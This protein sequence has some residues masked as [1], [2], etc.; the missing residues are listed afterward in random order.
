M[1]SAAGSTVAG[2]SIFPECEEGNTESSESEDDIE[3]IGEAGSTGEDTG[4]M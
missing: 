3:S 4:D 2:H 1:V